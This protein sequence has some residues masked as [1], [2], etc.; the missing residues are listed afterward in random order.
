[1][2]N[3]F[4]KAKPFSGFAGFGGGLSLLSS[5]GV[6]EEIFDTAGTFTWIAPAGVTS[7]CV[8]CI[9]GGGG[10]T[11]GYIDWGPPI[12]SQPGGAGGGAGGLGWK[13]NISV[14]PGQSYTVVVGAGGAGVVKNVSSNA[15][16][17]GDSYF[18]STGTVK[19]GGGQGGQYDTGG[20]GGSYTGDGG[21]NG[22]NGSN[23]AG[24]GGAGS[25]GGAGG[26]SGN[27][28]PA[29]NYVTYDP[30]TS[31]KTGYPGSGGGG[32]GGSMGWGNYGRSGGG[33]DIYGQGINGEG[34]G[35]SPVTA[36]DQPSTQNTG[37]RQGSRYD[38]TQ[39]STAEYGGAGGGGVWAGGSSGNA[40]AVRIIWGQFNGSAASFPNNASN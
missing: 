16:S 13:N 23:R 37:G 15:G 2:L 7:V 1:M 31:F 21:G 35:T 12:D 25:G 28:G 14:T 19:G 24:G 5:S 34:G 27:G 6:N 29:A 3:W 39:V 20:T 38:G 40:G 17:G 9:G 22:G 10:A 11:G 30:A 26:Y 33:T 32:G 4:R 8:V 18:I 36:G